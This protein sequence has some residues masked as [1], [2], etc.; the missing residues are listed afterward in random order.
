M[1]IL[2]NI[3]TIITGNDMNLT[4]G[5]IKNFATIL[6]EKPENQALDREMNKMEAVT[7][8]KGEIEEMLQKGYSLEDISR[9][10]KENDIDLQSQ[11]LKSYFNKIK[12]KTKKPRAKSVAKAEKKGDQS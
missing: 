1:A 7:L 11:T 3:L 9:L 6:R 2:R 10:A 5:K 12:D 8:L 4:L